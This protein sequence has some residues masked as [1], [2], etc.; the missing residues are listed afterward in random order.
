[1]RIAKPRRRIHPDIPKRLDHAGLALLFRQR[2]LMHAEAFG[3][4]IADRHARAQCAERI[5]E[6][7][8]H[9]AAERPHRLEAQTLDIAAQKHNRPIGGNQPQQRKAERGLCRSRIR[10]PRPAF[11]PCVP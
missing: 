11:R 7:D 3:D 8:L 10:R 4:D 5:L 9:V 6:Y 2:A 1:M